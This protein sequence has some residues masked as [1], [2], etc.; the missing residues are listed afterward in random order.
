MMYHKLKMKWVGVRKIYFAI[1]LKQC[2]WLCAVLMNK[3][4]Y[5]FAFP[6]NELCIKDG[7]TFKSIHF[8]F[9]LF[10]SHICNCGASGVVHFRL[11]GLYICSQRVTF[12]CLWCICMFLLIC[13]CNLGCYLLVIADPCC[14]IYLYT[15]HW[16]GQSLHTSFA[17]LVILPWLVHVFGTR[18][19]SNSL[20]LAKK[21]LLVTELSPRPR[22]NY[23]TTASFIFISNRVW[24]CIILYE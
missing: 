4:K 1:I 16:D 5:G 9:I 18:N 3:M 7:S 22:I 8:E 24:F 23:A 11:Q 12:T 6:A 19:W 21:A 2:C 10:L 20:V 15:P 14:C 17:S 13:T